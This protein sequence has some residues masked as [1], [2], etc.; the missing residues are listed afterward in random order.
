MQLCRKRQK[1]LIHEQQVGYT[2]PL[3]V[4]VFAILSYY[5][6][7]LKQD[8]R[9]I[10][11]HIILLHIK[12]AVCTDMHKFLM[13]SC[14]FMGKVDGMLFARPFSI[15]CRRGWHVRKLS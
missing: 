8:I 11:S 12:C 7:Q 6:V 2:E 15:F 4:V 13:M 10:F 3:A 9:M 5:G 14:A 1:K